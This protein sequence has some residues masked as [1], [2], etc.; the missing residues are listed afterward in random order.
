VIVK[1]HAHQNRGRHNRLAI[2]GTGAIEQLASPTT[3]ILCP[4]IDQLLSVS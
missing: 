3:T 1:S 2:I 4:K